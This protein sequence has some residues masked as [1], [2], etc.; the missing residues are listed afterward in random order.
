MNRTPR[1]KSSTKLDRQ[2]PL[3]TQKGFTP[4]PTT[5]G[6][7]GEALEALKLRLCEIVRFD[8]LELYIE[9]DNGNWRLRRPDEL[10]PRTRRCIK[11]L[12]RTKEGLLYYEVHDK[13]RAESDLIKLL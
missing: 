6:V 9:K 1:T 11:A 4:Y 8:P 12:H 2:R 5:K 7:S 13:Q 10:S 3:T